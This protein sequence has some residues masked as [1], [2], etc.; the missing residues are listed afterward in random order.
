MMNLYSKDLIRMIDS[1]VTY[2]LCMKIRNITTRLSMMDYLL[3]VKVKIVLKVER[4][5]STLDVMGIG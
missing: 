2:R 5:F 1:F 4:F 3:R